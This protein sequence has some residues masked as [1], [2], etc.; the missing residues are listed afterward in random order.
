MPYTVEPVCESPPRLAGKIFG[1]LDVDDFACAPEIVSMPRYVEAKSGKKSQIILYSKLSYDFWES[2]HCWFLN[3][4]NV[5][6]F[7]D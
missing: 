3:G 5:V 7:L 6:A 1:S 4:L 2:I